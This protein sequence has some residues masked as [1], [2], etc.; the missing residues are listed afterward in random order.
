MSTQQVAERWKELWVMCDFTSRLDFLLPWS[1]TN[2]GGGRMHELQGEN[3]HLPQ[4]RWYFYILINSSHPPLPCK[5][6][7]CFIGKLEGAAV[8]FEGRTEQN[9]QV[10]SGTREGCQISEEKIKRCEG[11]RW[12]CLWQRTETQFCKVVVCCLAQ[13]KCSNKIIRWL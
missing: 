6:A 11:N 4:G 3:Y 12:M 5:K 9:A 2:G 7:S 8:I 10:S 13:F 1:W